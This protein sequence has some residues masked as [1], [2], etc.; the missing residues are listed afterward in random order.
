MLFC[1]AFARFSVVLHYL[2][3]FGTTQCV[4]E[5]IE[6][7]RRKGRRKGRGRRRERGGE[8]E[9]SERSERSERGREDTLLHCF[10]QVLRGPLERLLHY[11]SEGITEGVLVS[12]L[13]ALLQRLVT[14]SHP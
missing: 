3:V 9:R 1:I 7:G 11:L 6:E 8:E 2:L 12:H 5:R 13:L 10:S 4:I 14:P